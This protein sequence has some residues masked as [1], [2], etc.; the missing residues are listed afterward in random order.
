V[1]NCFEVRKVRKIMK[2]IK[3]YPGKEFNG[4]VRIP[5]SKPETQRALLIG[6][7]TKGTSR[8]FNDQ[9]ILDRTAQPK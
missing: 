6:A 5:S 4:A 9:R 2:F 1:I 3:V 7:F 8:I